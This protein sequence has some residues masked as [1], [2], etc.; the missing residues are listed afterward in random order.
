MFPVKL[1]SSG[2]PLEAPQSAQPSLQVDTKIN[3]S[4]FLSTILVLLYFIP[5]SEYEAMD[6]YSER[7]ICSGS[8]SLTSAQEALGV[9]VY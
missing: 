7:R 1:F 3:I 4:T 5:V 8:A 2:S 6:T 9:W